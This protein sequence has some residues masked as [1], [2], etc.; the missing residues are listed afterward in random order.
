MASPAMIYITQ[1][2]CPL[3]NRSRSPIIL[4]HLTANALTWVQSLPFEN[5]PF[6]FNRLTLESSVVVCHK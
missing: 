5:A 2:S 1:K 6:V 3:Y 4:F